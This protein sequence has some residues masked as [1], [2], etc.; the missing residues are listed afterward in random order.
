M[1]QNLL[2]TVKTVIVCL[3]YKVTATIVFKR[4]AK[5]EKINKNPIAQASKN[6]ENLHDV[7]N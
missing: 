3:R 4:M 1:F 5:D 6:K 7:H 2:K